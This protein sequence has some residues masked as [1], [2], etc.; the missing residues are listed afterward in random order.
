MKGLWAA[1]FNLSLR[2]SRLGLSGVSNTDS[3]RVSR[4]PTEIAKA[5]RTRYI[6]KAGSHDL[7][8]HVLTA[9]FIL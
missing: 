5:Q 3:E 2:A 8:T 9:Y 1:Y 6:L 4:Y 7:E